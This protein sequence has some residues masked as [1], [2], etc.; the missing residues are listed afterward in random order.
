[1]AYGLPCLVSDI[2]PHA[3]VVVDGVNGFLFK[4]GDLDDMVAKVRVI[5]D[6]P[7]VF[8]TQVAK[9]AKKHVREHYDW[10]KVVDQHEEIF[11]AIS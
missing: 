5:L 7:P 11:R 10:E 2:S 3:E 8:S 1:M 4:A 6:S 9:E